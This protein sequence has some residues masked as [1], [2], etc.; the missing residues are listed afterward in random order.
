MAQ[1]CQLRLY[2][3]IETRGRVLKLSF[4]SF[5]GTDDKDGHGLINNYST[6]ARWK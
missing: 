5:F 6:S 3:G 4:R 2:L 1:V